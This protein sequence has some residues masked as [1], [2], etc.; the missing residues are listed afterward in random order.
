MLETE[1]GKLDFFVG[2]A[3]VAL[4]GFGESA[5]TLMTLF[6]ASDNKVGNG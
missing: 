5:V 6:S 3:G 2:N 4:Q 1:H